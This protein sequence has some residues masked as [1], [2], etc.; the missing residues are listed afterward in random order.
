MEQL[1]VSAGRTPVE[2]I[3]AGQGFMLVSRQERP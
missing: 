3:N 1:L 2:Q